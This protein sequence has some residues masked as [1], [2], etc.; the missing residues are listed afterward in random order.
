[1]GRKLSANSDFMVPNRRNRSK[2]APDRSGPGKQVVKCQKSHK[3]FTDDEQKYKAQIAIILPQ[4]G[5]S[6]FQ[7]GLKQVGRS[8][9]VENPTKSLR[10]T[11]RKIKRKFRFYVAKQAKQAPERSGTG[12]QVG[13]GRR[14]NKIF[15]GN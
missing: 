12:K 1:M 9:K 14:P 5:R 10:R 6:R 8:E 7:T 11:E 3:I 2:H 4:A 13:K 15:R